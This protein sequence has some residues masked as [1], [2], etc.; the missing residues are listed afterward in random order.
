MVMLPRNNDVL[1]RVVVKMARGINMSANRRDSR[2]REIAIVCWVAAHR[3]QTTTTITVMMVVVV[4]VVA[5]CVT[6]MFIIICWKSGCYFNENVYFASHA[7]HQT[8]IH[9][10]ALSDGTS[11]IGDP[12][13]PDETIAS[14]R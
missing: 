2:G 3:P 11:S 13:Q 4:V 8:T 6:V 7:Y 10:A 1:V 5:R 14:S 12:V 9:S